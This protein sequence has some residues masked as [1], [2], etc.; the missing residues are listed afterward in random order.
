M[1]QGR[2]SDRRGRDGGDAA[3]GQGCQQPP[4][5]RRGKAWTPR[6]FGVCVAVPTSPSPQET[7]TD[8]QASR[9]ERHFCFLKSIAGHGVCVHRL[10][11]PQ[12]TNGSKGQCQEGQRLSHTQGAADPASAHTGPEPTAPRLCVLVT[13]RWQ[14]PGPPAGDR[15]QTHSAAAMGPLPPGVSSP[16]NDAL[17]A[18]V[19]VLGEL[20]ASVKRGPPLHSGHLPR[21]AALLRSPL[22]PR[23]QRWPPRAPACGQGRTQSSFRSAFLT[24]VSNCL[25][26]QAGFCISG[27]CVTEGLLKDSHTLHWPEPGGGALDP[28]HPATLEQISVLRLLLVGE[29]QLLQKTALLGRCDTEHSVRRPCHCSV[30]KEV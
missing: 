8:L 3:P 1:Q 29:L 11:Q 20:T 12:E 6:T 14:C 24:T 28:P 25:H 27:R 30:P 18:G 22:G 23:L 26:V 19:S 4:E 16:G 21:R 17:T 5:A 10:Q 2:Q 13:S 15:S 9:T 7:G